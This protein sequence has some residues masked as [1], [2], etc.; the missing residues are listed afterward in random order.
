MLTH[1]CSKLASDEKQQKTWKDRLE[2]LGASGASTEKVEGEKP[3]LAD[4]PEV[5]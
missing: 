3:A 1:Y 4:D 2:G 5:A